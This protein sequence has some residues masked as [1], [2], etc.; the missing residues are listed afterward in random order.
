MMLREEV[1]HLLAVASGRSLAFPAATGYAEPLGLRKEEVTETADVAAVERA[2]RSGK[3]VGA[4]AHG[5]EDTTYGT[6][7]AGAE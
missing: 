2:E 3:T 7:S 4:V 5:L 1:D 6:A